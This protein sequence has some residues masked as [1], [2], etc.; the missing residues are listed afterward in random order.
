MEYFQELLQASLEQ[1]APGIRRFIFSLNRVMSIYFQIDPGVVIG[2]HSH[3]Q[4]QM[5]ML[6][7]GR[8][9]WRIG[10]NETILQAPALYRVPSNEPHQVEVLGNETMI[11]L[12]IFSPVREDF[13][14]KEAPGY[15]IPKT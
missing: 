5:G 7:Q 11:V 1:I 4:E 8:M 2:Q 12:D 13:L 3:P 6:I 10:D 9:K 15:F 14:K